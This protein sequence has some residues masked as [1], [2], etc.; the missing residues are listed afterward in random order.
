MY[1]IIVEKKEREEE[2]E[3]DDNSLLFN[4]FPDLLRFIEE[5][6]TYLLQKY[7]YVY[8]DMGFKKFYLELRYLNIAF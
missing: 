5:I 4:L 6:Y 8:I 2:R 1:D 3:T 7:V